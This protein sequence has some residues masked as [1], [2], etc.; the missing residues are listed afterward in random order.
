MPPQFPANYLFWCS[1]SLFFDKLSSCRLQLVRL[2]IQALVANDGNIYLLLH[3]R[4][5]IKI[6]PICRF[7]LN[8]VDV[9]S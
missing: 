4:I 8:K 9:T 3:I 2:F 5:R 1:T 7:Q 6:W